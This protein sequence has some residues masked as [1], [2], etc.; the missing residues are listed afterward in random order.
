MFYT[1]TITVPRNTLQAQ[2][3]ITS[4]ILDPGEIVK[5]GVGFPWGLA[6]LTYVQIWLAEHQ[7]WPTN[8]GAAFAWNDLY[9]WWDESFPCAGPEEAW[10]IRCWNLDDRYDQDV[11]VCFNI[12]PL[13]KTLLGKIAESLFGGPRT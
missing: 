12:L 8:S 3:L 13:E 11:E 7:Q 1:F 10:S 9:Y 4:I 5:V 2:P 6:G